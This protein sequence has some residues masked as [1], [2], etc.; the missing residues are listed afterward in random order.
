MAKQLIQ[1]TSIYPKKEEFNKCKTALLKE[2]SYLVEKVNKTG[3]KYPKLA[4]LE[5]QI[6]AAILE[7]ETNINTKITEDTKNY[8]L[9]KK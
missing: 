8:K 5:N 2:L 7:V 9:G 6:K 4:A 1:S 3:V